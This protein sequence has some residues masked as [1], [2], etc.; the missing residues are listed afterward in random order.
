MTRIRSKIFRFKDKRGLTLIELMVVVGV[1]AI[2]LG[3]LIGELNS[4]E[5]FRQVRDSK[6]IAILRNLHFM[7]TAL[8]A[9]G[10]EF[11]L[12]AP[13]K[14]Y[15][16]IPDSSATCANLGL[17]SLPPGWTYNC[18]A[19]STLM[20]ADG[21]GWLPI[22]FTAASFWEPSF[23]LPVDPV[24]SAAIGKYFTYVS[25]TSAWELAAFLESEKFGYGGSRDVAGVDNGTNPSAFE[26]GTDLTLAPTD[27]PTGRLMLW[28]RADSLGFIDEA[29]VAR[30]PDQS[31]ARNDATEA[32]LSN[33]PVHRKNVLNGKPVV[34]FDGLDD[35]LQ[36]NGPF[37]PKDTTFFIVTKWNAV[38]DNSRVV[39]DTGA[40]GFLRNIGTDAAGRLMRP[41]N[42]SYKVLYQ[43][44]AP[45]SLNGGS[46]FDNSNVRN[47][48][49]IYSMQP[50]LGAADIKWFGRT[51]TNN[52]AYWSGDIAEVI[53][54]SYAMTDSERRAVEK[55]LGTKYGLTTQ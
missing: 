50:T 3:V 23:R 29:P 8:R 9:E 16:S 36:F 32:N 46:I 15:V 45:R 10:K 44:G 41:D 47:E 30:W 7:I 51:E 38:N 11:S 43:S 31:S 13:S 33:Q 55:Y 28:L 5:L 19:S 39:G 49:F 4:G 52:A 14:V 37:N 35:W 12:G 48:F 1:A 54:Y 42:H 26:M 6:R 24:N 18:V 40:E 2:I 25:A 34:R 21:T 17:P 27:I 20:N 22:D 53:V